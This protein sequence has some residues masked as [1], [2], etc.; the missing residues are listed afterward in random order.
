M[1]SDFRDPECKRCKNSSVCIAVNNLYCKC[2][3]CKEW[4]EKHNMLTFISGNDVYKE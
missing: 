3:V 1:M 2:E 4:L